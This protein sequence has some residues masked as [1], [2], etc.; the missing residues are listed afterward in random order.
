MSGRGGGVTRGEVRRH[1]TRRALAGAATGAG[2][3]ATVALWRWNPSAG[4]GPGL[5]V[6][7]AATGLHCPGCG[8]LRGT[9][10]LLHGRVV[11][12]SRNALWFAL[13]PLVGY[14]GASEWLRLWRGRPLPTGPLD[15]PIVWGAFAAIAAA[16]TV[17]RNL[18]AMPWLWLAP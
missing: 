1:S 6:I 8:I 18:D 7:H 15:R 12:V 14:I 9:H 16:F 13:L 11:A 2:L 10:D 4:D 5:C 17:M 3:A